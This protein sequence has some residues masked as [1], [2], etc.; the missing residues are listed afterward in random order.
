VRQEQLEQERLG[1]PT[2][3]SPP[4]TTA[5]ATTA[6]A[7]GTTV[8]VNSSKLGR[9]LVDAKGRTLYLFEKDKGTTSSCYGACAGT[10][11]L[12]LTAIHGAA[13]FNTEWLSELDPAWASKPKG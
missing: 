4:T 7:G 5:P 6:A 11:Q 12:R 1:Q 3:T 13:E 10:S 2:A 8:T 9:I